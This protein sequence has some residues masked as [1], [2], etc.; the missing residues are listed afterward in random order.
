MRRAT[1]PLSTGRAP[2]VMGFPL[3]FLRRDREVGVQALAL[4]GAMGEGD[5]AVAVVMGDEGE[6]DGGAAVRGLP[7]DAAVAEERFVAGP[8]QQL[9]GNLIAD[10]GAIL[11]PV[12]EQ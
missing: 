2:S 10:L 8:E 11:Q 6:L 5:Q 3:R 9:E 7:G 1:P 4:A 12:D